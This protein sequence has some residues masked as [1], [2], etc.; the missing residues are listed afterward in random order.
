E[1][2]KS[3]KKGKGKAIADSPSESFVPSDP[4]PE[5]LASAPGVSQ[6]RDLASSWDDAFEVPGLSKGEPVEDI[7]EPHP[8][9]GEPVA[10]QGKRKKKKSLSISL[11]DVEE[12][13]VPAE[14]GT[15]VEGVP[16]AEPEVTE[17]LLAD[18]PT[19]N[20]RS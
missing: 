8:E 13:S 18:V 1:K 16:T 20:D 19:E 4:N 14:I 12:P 7:A 5:E 10:K 9:P 15:P 17:A 6:A 3:G 2:K 11:K